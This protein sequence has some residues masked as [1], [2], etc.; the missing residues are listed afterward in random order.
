MDMILVETIQTLPY[1]FIK[2]TTQNLA[3]KILPF[4]VTNQ[5]EV[6]EHCNV[7][8]VVYDTRKQVTKNIDSKR[9]KS[10]SKR[11]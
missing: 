3:H 1:W 5:G 7:F 6:I 4:S 2:A 10:E 11:C 9:I 8:F